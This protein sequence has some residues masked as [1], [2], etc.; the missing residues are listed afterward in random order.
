LA[1]SSIVGFAAKR[2]FLFFTTG[3]P[4]EEWGESLNEEPGD[5]IY[6][7]QGTARPD[8]NLCGIEAKVAAVVLQ[9]KRP[10]TYVEL[11][12]Q[13][14]IKVSRVRK[15]CRGLETRGLVTKNGWKEA[16]FDQRRRTVASTALLRDA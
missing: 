15:V 4:V 8:S 14:G 7:D 2:L 10:I 11:S 12:R 5:E 3:G 16:P 13:A 6:E 9:S 1:V